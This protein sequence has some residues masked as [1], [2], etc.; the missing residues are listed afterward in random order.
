MHPPSLASLRVLPTPVVRRLVG[1]VG[2]RAADVPGAVLAP[3]TAPWLAHSVLAPPISDPMSLMLFCLPVRVSSMQAA[4]QAARHHTRL[5][6]WPMP[7][8][9]SKRQVREKNLRG[10]ATTSI[11]RASATVEDAFDD[12]QRAASP[13]HASPSPVPTKTAAETP[14]V[15]ICTIRLDGSHV[16]LHL[17]PSIADTATACDGSPPWPPIASSATVQTPPVAASAPRTVSSAASADAPDGS[18]SASPITPC[19]LVPQLPPATADG[20][21]AHG[22]SCPPLASSAPSVCG[23]A[24]DMAWRLG[25]GSTDGST[26][27]SAAHAL[28]VPLPPPPPPLTTGVFDAD[29]ALAARGAD[30]GDADDGLLFGMEETGLEGG[31]EESAAAGVA[32]TTP[33]HTPIAP[34]SH[35]SAWSPGRTSATKQPYA[36][37]AGASAASEAGSSAGGASASSSSSRVAPSAAIAVPAPAAPGDGDGDEE[38]GL[39]GSWGKAARGHAR[40]AP[41]SSRTA[42]PELSP[43]QPGVAA[44][45]GMYD[46]EEEERRAA[47]E[48]V[49]IAAAAD[50]A[51]DAARAAEEEEGVLC[52]ICHGNIAPSEVALVRGCDHPF[53][54]GCILNWAL[55]KQ[56]CPLCLEPFTHLW[57][58]RRIDGTYNDFLHEESVALLHCAVWFKKQVTGAFAAPAEDDDADGYGAPDDYHAHLQWM[59]GGAREDDEER[60]YYDEMQDG[61]ELRGRRSGGRA[62]GQRK[63]GSGGFVSAGG[64]RLAARVPAT[65]ARSPKCVSKKGF[66]VSAGD[67]GAGSSS[68]DAAL[69]GSGSSGGGGA[70]SKAMS[71]RAEKAA[72]KEAQKEKR[73][74]WATTAATP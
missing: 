57:L 73:R 7:S 9:K 15:V 24:A 72:M 67:A 11:P 39:F 34:R 50:A 53:C 68:T 56:R 69:G 46:D 74:G 8:K 27:G 70:P 43:T 20:T 45:P 17:S 10:Y 58:Y 12:A 30:D 32:A 65:P 3:V 21:R 13:V 55:Q 64:P 47:E 60:D 28:A 4:A 63:F 6:A 16:R 23:L 40:S 14:R 61:L 54:S 62:F 37:A 22:A 5:S 48:A 44:S 59:Y 38:L 52:A 49:A 25:T 31:R 36:L 18:E 1:S 42:W 35:S 66:A 71:K 19:T 2:A 26:D 51:E 41:V 29:G 33:A